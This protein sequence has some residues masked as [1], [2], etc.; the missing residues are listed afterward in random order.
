MYLWRTQK[1]LRNCTI[2]ESPPMLCK[3]TI[4]NSIWLH[5]NLIHDLAYIF[6]IV[7]YLLYRT[8]SCL[9]VKLEASGRQQPMWHN[10]DDTN[11]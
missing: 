1:L 3:E 5:S 9:K 2:G 10:Q 11:D 4:V 8:I 6:V 7:A